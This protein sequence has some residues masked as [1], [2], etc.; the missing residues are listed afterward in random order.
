MNIIRRIL[1][2]SLT[3]FCCDIAPAQEKA[4]LAERLREL[5]TRV[6]P[7]DAAW[8]EM[9][10][11]ATRVGIQEANQRE[12]ER[13][14]ALRSRGDWEQYRDERVARL[15]ASLGVPPEAP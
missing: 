3:L 11:R 10:T 9:L 14:H 8:R 2:L 5:P 13:W 7:A 15:R 12:S 1:S 6:L 4:D